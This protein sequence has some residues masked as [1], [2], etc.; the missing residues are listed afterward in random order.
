M[1][2]EHNQTTMPQAHRLMVYL[3]QPSQIAGK[4]ERIMISE[5]M[6]RK[7]RRNALDIKETL[8]RSPNLSIIPREDVVRHIR[9]LSGRILQ[10]T[11][12]LLDQHLL[13]KSKGK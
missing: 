10:M 6:L 7:W 8:E 11:Q 3:R 9:E 13:R 4:G 12:E 2:L 1:G 5:R